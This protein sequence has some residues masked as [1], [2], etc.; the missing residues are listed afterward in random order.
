MIVDVL[1]KVSFTPLDKLDVIDVVMFDVE[2]SNIAPILVNSATIEVA[3]FT[4]LVRVSFT[5]LDR[6]PVIEVA[7]LDV[8]VK[9]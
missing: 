7:K 8:E 3:I 1:V 2:V 6:L 5:P 4:V 9:V